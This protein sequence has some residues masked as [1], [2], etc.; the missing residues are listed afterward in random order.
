MEGICY[1]LAR[2]MMHVAHV[3]IAHTAIARVDIAHVWTLHTLTHCCQL[4][5]KKRIR[6]KYM[7]CALQRKTIQK[8]LVYYGSGWVGPGIT[9]NLLLL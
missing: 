6:K 3:D 5:W 7:L 4:L 1:D 8:I 9:Q 2:H